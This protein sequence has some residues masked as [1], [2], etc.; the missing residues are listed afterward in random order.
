MELDVAELFHGP[1]L[2]F[3]DLGLQFI[4]HMFEYLV[5]KRQRK[6][7]II[8]ATSGDTGACAVMRVRCD[9]PGR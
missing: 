6:L 2:A 8:V 5:R 3:K 9:Q 1:T 7:S 4:G